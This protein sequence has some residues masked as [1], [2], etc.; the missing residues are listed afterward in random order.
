MP[1]IYDDYVWRGGR[2]RFG[3]YKGY[4]DWQKYQPSTFPSIPISKEPKKI[5]LPETS[6]KEKI[7]EL[8]KKLSDMKKANFTRD[9]KIAEFMRHQDRLIKLVENLTD[10]CLKLK[11]DNGKLHKENKSIKELLNRYN[12]FDIMEINEDG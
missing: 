6:T 2:E 8:E 1:T 11:E 3:D 10:E 4:Q 5:I 9:D 7:K 12:R